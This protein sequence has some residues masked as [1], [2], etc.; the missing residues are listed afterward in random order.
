MTTIEATKYQVHIGGHEVFHKITQ[1]LHNHKHSKIFILVDENSLQYC[2]PELVKNVEELKNAEIIETESGEENKTIE[3]C[4]Q[5]WKVLTELGADR[6]SL[7]INLGGGVIGDLGGFTAACFKR[8]IRYIN[9]PTTLLAQV[10]ASVGGKTGVDLENL[11]N[12][13]GAFSDPQ[14]VFIYPQFLKTLSKKQV[15][16][17]LAEVVKHA[18]IAD[19]TYW[20]QIK[21]FKP[22]I[23]DWQNIIE[24]SVQLKNTIVKEDPFEYGK[25]K[26]LNFGHTVG[27]AL[28]S[29]HLEKE[30][31]VLH[32]EAIAAGMICE[33]FLSYKCA[34][35]SHT[36]L[37]EI[38]EFIV[39]TF[40]LISF[41]QA[42]YSRLIELMEQDKKN[43]GPGINFTLLNTLG[44]AEINSTCSSQQIF[45]ALDFYQLK[46][47]LKSTA[48]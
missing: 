10:D 5:L 36:E 30:T 6:K 40:K 44:K 19:A 33:S 28:E 23:Q 1:Y 25:R 41:E 14:A 43:E 31:P 37:D 38:C 47:S 12:Q 42:D 46:L 26:L 48:K 11:K 32:G 8:G 45:Q 24:C 2:I 7:L 15:L 21:K 4:I 34:G 3:V 29:L 18:L 35:L 22:A 20:K 39:K 16:S 13:I 27:H 9:I 17:G